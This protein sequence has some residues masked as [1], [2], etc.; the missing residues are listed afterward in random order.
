MV[1]GALLKEAT[2]KLMAAGVDT[3]RLDSEELLS[4]LLQKERLYLLMNRNQEMASE[5]EKAFWELIERRLK[6]EPVAYIVG[7]REFMSLNFSVCP[8]ILIPRPDTE[9]LVEYAIDAMKHVEKPVVFCNDN[10]V[11]CCMANSFNKIHTI[12]YLF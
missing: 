3:A 7:Q 11:A 12:D 1:I 10:A 2:E 4:F 8:G 6:K 5:T 9:T